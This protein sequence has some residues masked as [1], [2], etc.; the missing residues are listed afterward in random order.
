[1]SDSKELSKAAIDHECSAGRDIKRDEP[2]QSAQ[3]DA[4]QLPLKI[5]D[6]WYMGTGTHMI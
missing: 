1:M 2:R 5:G 6:R 4:P 3:S